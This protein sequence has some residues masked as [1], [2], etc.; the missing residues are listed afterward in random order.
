MIVL[1]IIATIGLALG[2]ATYIML[3]TTLLGVDQDHKKWLGLEMSVEV[4]YALANT[5][6]DILLVH[7]C[8]IIWGRQKKVAIPLAA[9]ALANN[10]LLIGATVVAGTHYDTESQLQFSRV[11]AIAALLFFV[12]NII[13]NLVIPLMISVRIWTIR[14]KVVAILGSRKDQN[15]W[16]IALCLETG[17][18]YPLALIPCL[19]VRSVENRISPYPVLLQVAC[20]AP[21]LII[22]RSGLGISIENVNDTVHNAK[23]KR[24]G[25]S[26]P[27]ERETLSQWT[28]DPGR[29]V[30]PH[31][32]DEED[33]PLLE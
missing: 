19:I 33:P 26:T 29:K 30:D 17:V 1:F 28:Q 32:R 27:G 7:R 16:N 11:S 5:V 22:V 14:R 9:L 2:A 8:Y 3:A 6:A 12:V 4:S 21:T 25:Y 23:G 18:V 20:I 31:G 13:M 10:G 24:S 15:N